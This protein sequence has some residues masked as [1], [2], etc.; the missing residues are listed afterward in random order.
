MELNLSG[1]PLR[2]TKRD[3][4]LFVDR[5]KILKLV[6][7]TVRHRGNVIVFG[8]NGSGKSS[9]LR[10]LKHVLEEEDGQRVVL[11]EGRVAKSVTEFLGLLRDRLNAWRQM[12]LSEAA[13][14]VAAGVGNFVADPRVVLRPPQTDAQTLLAELDDLRATL[15]EEEIIVLVDE[16]PSSD[17]ARTLFGRLRDELW[18]L[19]LT[20][21]VVADERDRSSFTAPPA[22]AFWRQ[23]IDLE[24]LSAQDAK[25][26]LR[27]R[28]GPDQ[29]D[30]DT[31][32]QIID[33]AEGN[34]RRLLS[35]AH[36][37]VVQGRAPDEVMKQQKRRQRRVEKLSEPAKRLLAELEA[38]G[39]AS[40]SDE[41]LLQRLGWSRS[42]ASQV[43]RELEEGG[44]VRATTQPGTHSRPRRF[45]EVKN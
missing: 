44:F 29:P 9:L 42:R 45:Y 5:A 24:P 23:V 25:V 28:L 21:C 38:G 4:A 41:G 12:R 13:G 15:P 6:R 19:P 8:Q 31:L 37:V 33:Q 2:D 30:E 10:F 40:P 22:D 20:W 26:L 11:V 16:M 39:G 43:F 35:L 32:A 27:R 7:N 36:E 34:P 1:R 14:A 18:E 3:R 17:V